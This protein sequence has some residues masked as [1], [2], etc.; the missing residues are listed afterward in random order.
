LAE[1]TGLAYI[2]QTADSLA[3]ES[4]LVPP[5][6]A[7]AASSAPHKVSASGHLN[8]LDKKNACLRRH[9]LYILAERTGL[10]PAT[11]DVTGRYSNQLNYH[12]LVL[13]TK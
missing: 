8:D 1:R 6:A 5:E 3:S 11:P 7:Q 4:L 12:S 13:Q 9:F 2:L 10:E